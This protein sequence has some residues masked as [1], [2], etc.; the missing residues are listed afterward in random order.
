MF[1]QPSGLLLEFGE[2]LKDIFSFFDREVGHDSDDVQMIQSGQINRL[3]STC[4]RAHFQTVAAH[5]RR[6]QRQVNRQLHAFSGGQF[7]ELTCNLQVADQFFDVVAQCIL[8]F[9]NG[10]AAQTHQAPLEAFFPCNTRLLVARHADTG[11][12][13]PDGGRDQQTNAI[14]I[15]VGFHHGTHL[16][17]TRQPLLKLGDVSFE[18]GLINLQPGIGLA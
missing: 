4:S 11:D 6:V 18:G 10:S 2:S 1:N 15:S 7:I 16:A 8:D 9:F 17:F 13:H 3:L 5:A 14:S 12:P